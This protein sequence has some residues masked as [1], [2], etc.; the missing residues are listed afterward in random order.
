MSSQ[1]PDVRN[2][3]VGIF[4]LLLGIF[5]L[6]LGLSAAS[7]TSLFVLIAF[8]FFARAIDSLT[9]SHPPPYNWKVDPTE[10]VIVI[11][12]F[13]I[14]FASYVLHL[15]NGWIWVLAG[16]A[17]LLNSVRRAVRFNEASRRPSR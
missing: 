6:L 1:A 16:L 8:V 3:S 11:A 4:A 9:G 5:A 13:A 7:L 2:N 12:A 17:F 15:F 14:T 10:G